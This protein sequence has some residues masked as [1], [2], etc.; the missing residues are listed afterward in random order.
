[1]QKLSPAQEVTRIVRDELIGL[2]G[3]ASYTIETNGFDFFEDC[4]TFESNTAPTN[5]DALRSSLLGVAREGC[6]CLVDGFRVPEFGYEQRP[7][8]DGDCTSAAIAHVRLK[9]WAARCSCS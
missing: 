7:I 4:A 1:M 8:V 2:L 6:V 3:V 9:S 5:L